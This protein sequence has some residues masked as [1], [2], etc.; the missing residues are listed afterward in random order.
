MRKESLDQIYRFHIHEIYRYLFSL[1]NDPYLA[2]DLLQETFYRAYLC[3]EDCN[4]DQ[5][6]PWLLKVAHN[7]LIDYLRKSKRSQPVRDDF[8]LTLQSKDNPEEEFLQKEKLNE[9][10]QLV[11]ALPLN[12]KQAILLYDFH[13]LS[14][15]QAADVME[16]KTNHFKVLLFRARQ[17]IRQSKEMRSWDE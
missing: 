13:N 14:Y 3:L 10:M 2:E 1:C 5:I 11:S 6:K 17:N 7:S 9:V 8:F 4:A 16:I 15:Q 12:Q